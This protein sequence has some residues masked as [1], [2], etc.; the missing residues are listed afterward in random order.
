MGYP[1]NTKRWQRGDLVIHAGDW[2]GDDRMLMRVTGYK[3][4][5]LVR[6][7]YVFPTG[8]NM[9]GVCWNELSWL[10]DPNDFKIDL[11]RAKAALAA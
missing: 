2:K 10:L 9:R 8:R 7:R 6:T 3:S 1:P 4:D 5:G 11:T